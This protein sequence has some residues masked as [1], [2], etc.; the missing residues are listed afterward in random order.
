MAF[1]FLVIAINA[2]T[3][4]RALSSIL[5]TSTVTL[6]AL[7]LLTDTPNNL[8]AGIFLLKLNKVAFKEIYNVVFQFL[9]IHVSDLIMFLFI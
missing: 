1:L 8:F 9:E 5:E 6:L 3:G 4:T 7:G 2:E